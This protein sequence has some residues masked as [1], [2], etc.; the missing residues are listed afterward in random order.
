MHKRFKIVNKITCDFG[1]ISEGGYIEVINNIIFVN[2]GQIMP[3]YYNFFYNLICDELNN[4]KHNYIREID[5]IYNQ[6]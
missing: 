1:E 6:I 3:L 2:G 4:R 5:M